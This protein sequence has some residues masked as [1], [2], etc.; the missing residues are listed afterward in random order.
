MQR[1]IHCIGSPTRNIL[2]SKRALQVQ[3]RNEEPGDELDVIFETA[4]PRRKRKL[5]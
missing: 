4:E 1:C 3:E 2:T 5:L